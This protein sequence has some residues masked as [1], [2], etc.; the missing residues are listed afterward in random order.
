[1]EEQA[2]EKSSRPMNHKKD[3][4]PLKYAGKNKDGYDT[5]EM[6][7]KDPESLKLW[8]RLNGYES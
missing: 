7:L 1:M 3:R 8:R 5:W 2:Q 4:G 6:D